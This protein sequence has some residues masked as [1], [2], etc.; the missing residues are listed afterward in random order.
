MPNL[1][2]TELLIILLLVVIPLVLVV[3][4]VR[5]SSRRSSAASYGAP[6]APGA[7]VKAAPAPGDL[8]E[9]VTRLIRQGKKIEAIRELRRHTS[10]GLA[11]AKAVADAVDAGHDMWGHPLMARFRPANPMITPVAGANG[12]GDLASRVR[13]LKAAG[14]AEQA[15]HLVRGETGMGER[16]AVLFVEAL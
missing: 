5:R 13:A 15:V 8:R 12:A 10:L 1:G 2:P 14:R 11:E 4:A 9:L 7:P 6:G 16:E 3:T